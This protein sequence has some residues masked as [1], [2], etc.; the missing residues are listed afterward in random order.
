M[1][2][3]QI[4]SV[5][6][7]LALVAIGVFATYKN[8]ASK[9]ER[10]LGK[11]VGAPLIPNF[12]LND[13]ESVQVKTAKEEANL[14]RENNTWGVK[15]RDNYPANFDF[16]KD[17]VTK[18]W[19]LKIIESTSVGKSQLG[20]LQLVDPTTIPPEEKDKV[21][22]KEIG[23]LVVFKKAGDQE[24][25]RLLLGKTIEGAAAGDNPMGFNL[26]GSA[27]RFVQVN[28]KS[29]VAY[30]IKEPFSSL[31]AD[32]K[33]W[34]DKAFIQPSGGLRKLEVKVTD[35][36]DQ[37]WKVQRDKEG[38]D[39]VLV[40][41]KEGEDIDAEKVKQA[42]SA[43]SSAYFNDIAPSADKEKAGVDAAKR[44]AT[45]AYFD[46]FTYTINVGNKVKAEDENSDYYLGLTVAYAAAPAPEEPQQA[47]P[48]EP[49]PT[50]AAANET[51][52]QKKEREKKDAD[53]KIAFEDA[54]KRAE[55]AKKKF[56]ED[57]KKWEED[58]KKKE[59]RLAKE[60]T[61]EGRV[62]IVSKYTVDWFLKDR[63]HFL[64]EKTAEPAAA[65]AGTPETTP[66]TASPATP[67]VTPP[68]AV[69]TPKPADGK[70]RR[71]EAVTP[72]V[73]V[74]IP[75]KKGE[76][77][78]AKKSPAP[79]PTPKAPAKGK[80][81]SNP[82]SAV[83]PPATRPPEPPLPTKA[84]E[85]APAATPKEAET[86]SQKPV[87]ETKTTEETLKEEKKEEA[88]TE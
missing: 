87:Q 38:A 32:S 84:S 4:I 70:P 59:E 43:F 74:E 64:K 44:V 17:L 55:D 75:P 23:T 37:S 60:K 3:R 10:G 83:T 42:G 33:S 36:A 11:E 25:A 34:L 30:K 20:R 27:G 28:N 16:V 9:T 48:V 39:P 53:A 50:K 51:E 6:V 81:P 54:K 7:A 76:K 46:G 26:G 77:P 82:P 45:I 14:V 29:D 52:E 61:Y 79:D 65:A 71:I 67:V 31:T 68:V 24:V 22:E 41:K 8:R 62:Y 72:P 73:T 88:K 56:E 86:P 19:E 1:N 57:K 80:T 15:E 5:L 63:K 21:D 13:V 47:A 69:G 66:A 18:P 12:P 78:G 85:S 49:Q 2:N 58:K 35:P 40:E